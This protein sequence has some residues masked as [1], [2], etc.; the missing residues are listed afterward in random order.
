LEKDN[1]S[2]YQ[3]EEGLDLASG[4]FSAGSIYTGTMELDMNEYEELKAAIKKGC[5]PIFKVVMPDR[6]LG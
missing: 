1:V 6:K 4:P 2:I 5:D 3:T